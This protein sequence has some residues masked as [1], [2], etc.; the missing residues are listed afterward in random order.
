MGAE[1][2]IRPGGLAAPLAEHVALA[3]DADVLQALTA[4]R[5][6]VRLGTLRFLE[7]R[8]RDLAQARLLGQR[9]RLIV[10]RGLERGA[11][12][13]ILHQP[14]GD[15]AVLAGARRV[16]EEANADKSRRR[17]VQKSSSHRYNTREIS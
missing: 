9:Q 14:R 13:G 5:I 12:A 8:G 6:G 16:R 2:Q 4:E 7:R 15:V 10:A 1:D 3:V 11:N 17:R